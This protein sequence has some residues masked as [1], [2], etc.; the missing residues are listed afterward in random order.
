MEDSIS[1]MIELRLITDAD[2]VAVKNWPAYTDIFEAM[3]Y[4]LR[5]DGWLD[6][7]RKR[8]ITW[9][10]MAELGG[11]TVGFS[12]LS[13]TADKEAEFRVAVHP[14]WIGKGLGSHIAVETLKKGFFQLNLT[15]IHLI[16]RKENPIAL[17]LYEGIGFIK[18][19]ESTHAIQGKPI[20]FIDM[21]M[22]REKFI[23]AKKEE[24]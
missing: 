20:E 5:E 12:L 17:K 15:R 11:Q 8:P 23:S 9:I 3:D 1:G 14:Q 4:A 6:E 19:G 13:T 24:G 10:Y 7:Y 21:D 22:S 18:Y 2:V 16:V